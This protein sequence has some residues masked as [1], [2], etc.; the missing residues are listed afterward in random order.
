M[1]KKILLIDDD[2]TLVE[3]MRNFLQTK[4]F[5]VSVAYDGT[6]GLDVAKRERPDVVVVDMLMPKQSGFLFLETLRQTDMFDVPVIMV[7]SN[8]G[9]RH[10]EYAKNLG[11][12][13]YINKPFTVDVLFGAVE[14]C[15]KN[16]T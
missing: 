5:S 8:D 1:Q 6:E 14:R 7:T 3:T 16:L 9:D 10:K 4:D 15:L 12:D 2:R 11:T 13:E